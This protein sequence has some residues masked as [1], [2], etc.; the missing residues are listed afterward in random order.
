MMRDRRMVLHSAS[1]KPPIDFEDTSTWPDYLRAALNG[2]RWTFAGAQQADDILSREALLGFH[3]T[4]LLPYEAAEIL[5]TGPCPPSPKFLAKRIDRAR[6]ARYL[7]A[8]ICT[9]LLAENQAA[10]ANRVGKIC[11]VNMR[12]CLR[13]E[14]SVR[15]FF[16]SWGGE[17]LYNSHE[18]DPI[19][20]PALKRL[21]EPY[22]VKV[23]VPVSMLEEFRYGL[24]RYFANKLLNDSTG[25]EAGRPELPETC[26]AGSVPPEWV[27]ELVSF[28]DAAFESLTHCHAQRWNLCKTRGRGYARQR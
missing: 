12:S 19:T 2:Y 25:G 14:S 6:E 10:D 7:P 27:V 17:V 22:I 18:E 28:R 11:F 4:R 3:C 5:E 24:A 16:E 8:N 21:G 15:R 20:G 26:V 13:E 1:Y 9:R 23:S